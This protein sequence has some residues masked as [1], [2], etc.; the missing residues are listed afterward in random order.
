MEQCFNLPCFDDQISSVR[1]VDLP[2]TGKIHGKSHIAFYTL[3]NCFGPHVHFPIDDKVNGVGYPNNVNNFRRY[4]LNDKIS[5]FMIWETSEAKMGFA[6]TCMA[7]LGFACVIF[8]TPSYAAAVMDAS[9]YFYTDINFSGTLF[10]VNINMTQ[11]CYS[12]CEYDQMSSVKW[13]G[14]LPTRGRI[15]GKAHIGFYTERNCI[16]PNIHVPIEPNVYGIAD[17]G[18]YAIDNEVSSFMIWET[19]ERIRNGSQLHCPWIS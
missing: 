15:Y 16:G 8:T 13:M 10:P 5:S 9:V 1:W 3:K 4:A 6:K 14:Q 17:L 18:D 11:K 2:S 12:L 7:V 19:S